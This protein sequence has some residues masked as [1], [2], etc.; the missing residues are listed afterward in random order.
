VTNVNEAP[1]VLGIACDG[2]SAV[3][4]HEVDRRAIDASTNDSVVGPSR[5]PVRRSACARIA[6]PNTVRSACTVGA[7][8]HVLEERPV[9]RFPWIIRTGIRFWPDSC[10]HAQSIVLRSRR[11][12]GDS[13]SSPC[14]VAVPQTYLTAG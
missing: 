11:A 1:A 10:A 3:A 9:E 12:G 6:N 7:P 5:S 14:V 4:S 2:G 8:D 13:L